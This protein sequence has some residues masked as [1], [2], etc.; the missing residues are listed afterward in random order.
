MNEDEESFTILLA[1]LPLTTAWLTM[2]EA[3]TSHAANPT[4]KLEAKHV[5]YCQGTTSLP[6]LSLVHTNETLMRID[7][8][9]YSLF[10]PS[11]VLRILK[12]V[13]K[14]RSV[15][16]ILILRNFSLTRP[17]L[18]QMQAMASRRSSFPILEVLLGLY[19]SLSLVP[20]LQSRLIH[21]LLPVSSRIGGQT[22]QSDGRAKGGI[23]E[24][25]SKERKERRDQSRKRES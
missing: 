2:A 16:L 18:Y 15:S 12:Q 1:L 13:F 6:H 19:V 11:R 20:P 23:R 24:G 17:T 3:S 9:M 22:R 8:A 4:G 5:L 14:V 25:P 21:L 10:I 7:G